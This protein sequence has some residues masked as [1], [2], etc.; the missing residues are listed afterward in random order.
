[1]F[2]VVG[3]RLSLTSAQKFS[4]SMDDFVVFDD[5]GSESLRISKRIFDILSDGGR[6]LRYEVRPC[7][8]VGIGYCFFCCSVMLRR[9]INFVLHDKAE[10]IVR[11]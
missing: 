10:A 9:M 3:D 2:G 11:V 4:W 1:L 8:V 7:H 6:R 5:G